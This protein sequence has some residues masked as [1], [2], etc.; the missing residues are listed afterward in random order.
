MGQSVRSEL[1]IVVLLVWGLVGGEAAR[2]GFVL[3][4][5]TKLPGIGLSDAGYPQISRDGLELYFAHDASKS[6]GACSDIWVMKRPSIQEAWSDPIRLDAPVNSAWAEQSPAISPNGLELYFSDAVHTIHTSCQ[7]HPDGYGKGDL[8]VARR[9]SK[10]DPWG[11][12]ENLGPA[13]NSSQNDDCP[14]LS[15]DGLSLFFQSDR[16]GGQ[17]WFDLYVSTRP[18]LDAPWEAPENLEWPVNTHND[19]T[20]PFLSPDGLSLYFSVAVRSWSSATYVSSM[21]VSHRETVSNPWEPPRLFAP[22]Q[23]PGLEYC[24]SFSEKDSALYFTNGSDFFQPFALWKVDVTRVL[25]FNEDGLV[26][27]SDAFSLVL[28][29][30]P[31]AS[32]IAG[33]YPL[34]DIA[35]FPCGDGVVDAKDLL[36]LAEYMTD[37]PVEE[38]DDALR[39]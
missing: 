4:E 16:S 3:G 14:S 24:V 33:E 8:W 39:R 23:I 19:E 34:Y 32:P 6:G 17:G 26:D 1:F 36:V 13:V 15:A 35:P 21:Y 22:V 2:G 29:W 31:A 25:D 9:A 11:T 18:S 20:T 7:P 10:Q 37:N 38:V 5:P 28:N 27:E 30:G 12:P